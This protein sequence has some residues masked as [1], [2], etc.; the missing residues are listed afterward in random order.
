MIRLYIKYLITMNKHILKSFIL[1]LMAVW[2]TL[3]FVSCL[4]DNSSTTDDTTT[5]DAQVNQTLTTLEQRGNLGAQGCYDLV[6]PVSIKL[7][8]G[9]VITAPSQDSLRRR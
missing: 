2:S 7:A 4:K 1:A 5:L 3:V 6:F 8:D 9:T